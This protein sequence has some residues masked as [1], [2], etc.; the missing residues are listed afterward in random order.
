MADAIPTW[1]QAVSPSG[2]WDEVVLPVV[3]RKRGMDAFYTTADGRQA[4]RAPARVP[5]PA[6]GT[7]GYDYTK[8]RARRNTRELAPDGEALELQTL[9]P[10]QAEPQAQSQP[11]VQPQVRQQ[12]EQLAREHA[13]RAQTASPAPFAH[14]QAQPV[15]VPALTTADLVPGAAPDDAD[16][17]GGAGCCKCVVM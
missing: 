13:R 9:P 1:T 5:E 2:N 6:P 10:P 14:Y 8:Y 4:V 7:F 17:G 11:Q 12:P 15:P 3:A 16:D